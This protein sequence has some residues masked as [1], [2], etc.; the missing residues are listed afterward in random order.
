M[1]PTSF[2]PQIMAYIFDDFFQNEEADENVYFNNQ[3]VSEFVE[4]LTPTEDFIIKIVDSIVESWFKHSRK[5]DVLVPV[6]ETLIN[7]RSIHPSWLQEWSNE[8]GSSEANQAALV[9]K[10]LKGSEEEHMF[11][12][13]IMEIETIFADL[14]AEEEEE[15][16]EYDDYGY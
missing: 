12:T 5:D 8:A 11:T 15:G 10:C 3:C 9:S 4:Y 7:N 1:F 13:W 16:D 6:F 2:F 14:L